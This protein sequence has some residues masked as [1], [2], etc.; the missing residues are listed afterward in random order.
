MGDILVQ[1]R[2]KPLNRIEMWAIGWQ[3]DQMDTTSWPGKK[4]PDVWSFMVGGVVPDHMNDALVGVARF[5]LGQKLRGTDP[6]NRC[7]LNKGRIEGLKVH[8]P[9]NVH[10]STPRRAENRRI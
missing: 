10:T 2:P 4:S 3:L 1:D 7:G 9:M 6:I 8:S 5:D